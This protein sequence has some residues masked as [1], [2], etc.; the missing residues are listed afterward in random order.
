MKIDAKIKNDVLDE[1][2]WQPNIDETKM[3]VIVED[4]VVD[5]YTKKWPNSANKVCF[6]IFF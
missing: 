4:D 6:F 1:L 5:Y 2:A 3:S